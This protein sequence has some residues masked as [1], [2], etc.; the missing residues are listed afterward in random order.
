MLAQRGPFPYIFSSPQRKATMPRTLSLVVDD[1]LAERLERHIRHHGGDEAAA[2]D[3]ALRRFLDQEDDARAA[4]DAITAA[5]Q[6]GE[7]G[8]SP[9]LAAHHDDIRLWLLSWGCTDER[10]RPRSC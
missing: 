6:E 3:H 10:K 8:A 2:L 9:I 5:A 4:H 7:A 1:H